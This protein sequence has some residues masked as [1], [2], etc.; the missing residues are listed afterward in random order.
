M[1]LTN[2][3]LN[4]PSGVIQQFTGYSRVTPGRPGIAVLAG[5]VTLNGPDVFYRLSSVPVG[6]RITISYSDGSHREFVVT[7]KASVDK[8]ALQ[9]DPRVWGASSTPTVALVTCD[10]ASG[11]A[12]AQHHTNNYVVWARPVTSAH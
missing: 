12:N 6:A 11:W 10:A 3:V 7:N 9:N 1:G 5:H 8:Q 4:P 2:G